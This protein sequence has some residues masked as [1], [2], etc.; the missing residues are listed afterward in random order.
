[1]IT[2]TDDEDEEWGEEEEAP[3]EEREGRV[4]RQRGGEEAE[5]ASDL[6]PSLYVPL[7]VDDIKNL[8]SQ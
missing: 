8:W 1:M 2:Y 3:G 4:C 6:P 7:E 5:E